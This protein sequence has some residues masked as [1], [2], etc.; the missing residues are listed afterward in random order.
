MHNTLWLSRSGHTLVQVLIIIWVGFMVSVSISAYLYAGSEIEKRTP[1]P[2][3]SSSSSSTHEVS[4][5][6]T[7]TTNEPNILTFAVVA[8]LVTTIGTLFGHV[9][10]EIFL[11]RS[12]ELWKSRRA[13][14]VV[15][16]KYR[17][18]ILLSAL[19]LA[20]RL[21]EICQEYPTDF[22]NS[23]LLECPIPS[24]GKTSER[25]LYFCRYKCQS[26][27]YRLAAFLAWLEL[28][29]Q[30]IVFLD[31]GKSS[32]NKRLQ[33]IFH[34]IQ[35]DL[36]DGHLNESEDW[37][38]WADALIFREEQRAIGEALI[39]QEG[40]ARLVASYG[41]FISILE[42]PNDERGRKWF[43]IL[44]NF[45]GDPQPQKDFRRVRYN[46]ILIHLIELA[47][48]LQRDAIS[49]MLEEA[50]HKSL[51]YLNVTALTRA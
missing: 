32:A 20:N 28:Y 14:D 10:K 27:A 39:K 19:E 33:D 2:I 47:R 1:A 15:F 49:E 6:A 9:L 51:K 25:D 17:D 26:T 36:A 3:A 29:R 13:T 4:N 22:L 48:E 24:A 40:D 30:E 46:R 41:T 31:T 44:A 38:E 45:F 12:F 7:H 18:P 35:S 11:A 23:S 43:P 37:Y 21:S 34:L 8:A 50:Y 5:P 16:R 42:D